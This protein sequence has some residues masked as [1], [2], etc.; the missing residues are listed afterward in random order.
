MKIRGDSGTN[1]QESSPS[2]ASTQEKPASV[3][4]VTA[5][6][7]WFQLRVAFEADAATL[8]GY[9]V[10]TFKFDSVTCK[11]VSV[12]SSTTTASVFK[13]T[14][15][16]HEQV[17]VCKVFPMERRSAYIRERDNLRRLEKKA[18]STLPKLVAHNDNN[19]QLLTTPVVKPLGTDR[20]TYHEACRLLGGLKHM[21]KVVKAVH[22]DV[23]EKHIGRIDDGR[24]QVAIF[25]MGCM[26]DL[27]TPASSSKTVKTRQNVKDEERTKTLGTTGAYRGTLFCA[28]NDV[29]ECIQ[30]GRNVTPHVKNDM[31]A[32]V[33]TMYII[34]HGSSTKEYNEAVHLVEHLHAGG[35]RSGA[36]TQVRQYWRSELDPSTPPGLAWLEL[37]ETAEGI[38]QPMDKATSDEY[39]TVFSKLEKGIGAMLRPGRAS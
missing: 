32:F 28:S 23:E 13:V 30:S 19:R 21:H 7:G 22:N 8:M 38:P 34:L 12:L 24:G 26:A 35:D 18:H 27:P 16:T 29:L 14:N 3:K 20:P 33:K 11:P 39:D 36:V 4:G 37:L 10:P 5:G 31:V 17:Q 9:F 1:T 2:K 15:E 6:E 25:D